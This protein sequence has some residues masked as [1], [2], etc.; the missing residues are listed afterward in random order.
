METSFY[1]QADFRWNR[2]DDGNRVRL[3]LVMDFVNWKTIVVGAT[4]LNEWDNLVIGLS[5]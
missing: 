2:P 4:T 3:R 1:L 5:E